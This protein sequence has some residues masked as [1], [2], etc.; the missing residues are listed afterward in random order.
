MEEVGTALELLAQKLINCVIRMG[1]CYLG[2]STD[3]CPIRVKRLL[4]MINSKN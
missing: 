3:S 1:E 4:L 2:T